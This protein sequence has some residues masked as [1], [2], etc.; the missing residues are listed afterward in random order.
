MPIS[1]K[2]APEILTTLCLVV[3]FLSTAAAN[4][5]P[6]GEDINGLAENA[7]LTTDTFMQ[8]SFKLRMQYEYSGR[9][10]TE[11]DKENLHKLAKSAGDH[12]Q[13][14]A[15]NQ[16]ELKNKI[17][18][19]RGDDW[20]AKYGST[21]LWRKL[22]S[23]L[24]KTALGK[25]E[26]DFYLAL[27]A[28]QQQRNN[29]LHK[30]LTEV[31]SLDLP[32]LPAASQL[33][34]AKVLALLAQTDPA[35]KPLAEKEHSM[36]MI[37]SD[38][39]HSTALRISIERIKLLGPNNADDLDK[40]TETIAKS[41][42]AD[43]IELVLSL[44]SLQ[45]KFNRPEGLEKI[46]SLWPQTEDFLGSLI[47][48]DLS[49]RIAQ[50]QSLQ[51]ISVFEAELA[52]QAAWKNET[53]DYET[54][55]SRLASAEKF[56]TPLILYVTALA[57]ADSSLTET[58]NLLIKASKL[59]Q[60]KKS[61]RLEMSACKIAEQAAWLAYNLFAADL[62]DCRPAL[63]AFENYSTIANGEIDEELEY[64]YSIVLDNCDRIEESKGLLAKIAD[65]PAGHWRN[66]AKLDLI[67]Q[68][69]EQEQAGSRQ[70]RSEVFEQLRE[71]ILNCRGQDKKSNKLRMEAITIYCQS[72]LELEKKDSAQNVLTILAEAETT[73]GA[74][75][76]LFKAQALQQLG[77]LDES[78]EYLL[79][80][81]DSNNCEYINEAMS[82]LSE[83]VD[84]IDRFEK[85]GLSFRALKQL[86]QFCYDCLEG[87][88]KQ[89]AGLFLIEVS[90]FPTPPREKKLSG[91][92][93]L[94]NGIAKDG[95]SGDVDFIR[96]RARLLTEQL[97]FDRAS[98]LWAQVAEMRKSESP[99]ANQRSWKWWRAKFYE[100]DC[101]A[102]R[103]QTQKTSVLHTIEVLENSFHDIPSLW[104]E[105]LNS[106]KHECRSNFSTG[107]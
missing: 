43:D 41:S 102:K 75:L 77:K 36:L 1:N 6:T 32:R 8:Q 80:A 88:A 72:L 51:Q 104:A 107:K 40:L 20:E 7:R 83:V 25:C 91:F 78:A 58:V 5:L 67:G 3:F 45:R 33:L 31:D 49:H 81:I 99:T 15:K 24:Y 10:L 12:L 70:Q 42:C 30:I 16:H 64:L 22:S 44:A 2:H 47:L 17:E 56:Q 98:R 71:L 89:R 27:T 38:M 57:F 63:E 21:G 37:R 46:V 66:R 69:I 53:K 105:K 62:L 93:K 29:I 50:Q 86:A 92:E 48:S 18:D 59:Q 39:R 11:D 61:D 97:K 9:F 4:T 106:L 103:P 55:L 76:N 26:I 90:I 101:W 65:R 100:L 96:C 85:S 84:T 60:Q 35:Y 68:A 82:L 94:L 95:L 73:R 87:Q 74:N 52:A 34:K 13:A 54:L 23:D 19:Y 79:R 28:A 14:I